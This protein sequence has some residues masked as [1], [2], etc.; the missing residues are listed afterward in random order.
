MKDAILGIPDSDN[1]KD[2]L[3]RFPNTAITPSF[4]GEAAL[5]IDNVTLKFLEDFLQRESLYLSRP[6]AM[7]DVAFQYNRVRV[8]FQSADE[9][10][11]EPVDS[12]EEGDTEIAQIGKK[13][14][15][16]YPR[17]HNEL[18]NIGVL[19]CRYLDR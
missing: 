2:L 9:E 5:Q 13:E 14:S 4:E 1:P 8:V 7:L 15:A 17:A 6:A 19:A 16:L 12:I 10:P 18:S 11:A 3:L